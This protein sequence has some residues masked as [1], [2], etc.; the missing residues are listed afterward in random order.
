LETPT[1]KGVSE[2][3]E[4][5]RAVLQ[6]GLRLYWKFLIWKAQKAVEKLGTAAASTQPEKK[7]G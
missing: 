6:R 7:I 5:V 3:L 1:L 2:N 4:A